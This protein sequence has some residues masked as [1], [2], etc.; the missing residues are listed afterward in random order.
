MR[1]LALVLA[2]FVGL[3]GPLAAS[4]AAHAQTAPPTV[5]RLF[6]PSVSEFRD[7]L[8]RSW[9]II[10]LDASSGD[11]GKFGLYVF[12]SVYEM[13]VGYFGVGVP[14]AEPDGTFRVHEQV[15]VV[16][17]RPTGEISPTGEDVPMTIESGSIQLSGTF[18]LHRHAASLGLQVDGR[19]VP[20]EA[21][22]P[23]LSG[24]PETANA[25]LNAYVGE[26][27]STLYGLYTEGLRVQ[28][29]Q[30]EFE[31]HMR[32]TTPP[33]RPSRSCPRTWWTRHSAP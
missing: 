15:P 17:Q 18:D 6:E 31:Q 11:F 21:N 8:D 12:P 3:F 22:E 33:A 23:D 29:T 5:R 30:A 24:A 16:I 14:V 28:V 7:E 25:A 20:L 32:E 9:I 26:D 13:A 2:L 10:D 19:D 27:W 4:D 1:S